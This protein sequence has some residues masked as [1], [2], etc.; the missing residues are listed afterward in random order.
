MKDYKSPEAIEI[1]VADEVILGF[2]DVHLWDEA[3]Q[4]FEMSSLSIVDVDE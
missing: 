1:G 2:K 4:D 3:N